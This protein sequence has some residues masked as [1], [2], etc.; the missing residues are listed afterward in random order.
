MEQ[1]LDPEGNGEDAMDYLF[2]AIGFDVSEASDYYEL[3][4]CTDKLGAQSSISRGAAKLQGYCWKLDDGLEV[5][6]WLCTSDGQ[7]FYEDCRPA[8]RSRYSH[9][10]DPWELIE[11]EDNGDALLRGLVQSNLHNHAARGAEEST[12]VTF[13]LQ[14]LTELSPHIFHYAHLHVAFAGLAYAAHVRSAAYL[15][16]QP[17][18]FEPA[19]GDDGLGEEAYDNEYVIRGRVAAWRY[20]KNSITDNELV[21]IYIDAE[22]IRLEIIINRDSLSGRLKVGA[23]ISARI[24]LQGYILAE[25]DLEARYEGVDLDYE[26]GDFWSSLQRRN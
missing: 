8:F 9:I 13:Q 26:V 3:I 22:R 10:L 21:W 16:R 15:K 4:E 14:N 5:W 6:S 12:Q 19:E 20:L 17:A 25:E 11:Y 18:V 2:E 24:W 1:E 7:V 23:A